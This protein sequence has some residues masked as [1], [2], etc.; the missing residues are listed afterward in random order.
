[1]ILSVEEMKSLEEKA[2]ADGV[3]ADVLMEEAGAQIARAVRQ[4]FPTPGVCVAV[5][6]KGNNGGDALVS[7]RHLAESGWEVLLIPAFSDDEWSPTVRRK[8][9]DAAGCHRRTALALEHTTGQP[10]VVLDGL[11]GIGA[12]GPLRDPIHTLTR[13]I[14]HLRQTAGA[15][16][17]ALDLPT[18]LNGDTGKAGT[19]CIIADTTLTIGFAKEGLLVDSATP[20]VGRLCVLPLRALSVRA[21]RECGETTVAT[22]SGLAHLLPRR[23]FD[24][25][26]GETGRIAVVAGSAPYMGAA[27]LCASGALRAGAG[28]VTL[29]VPN[30]ILQSIATRLPPEIILQ[31]TFALPEN[32]LKKHDVIAIGP[33]LGV[34]QRGDISRFVADCPLPMVVDAD[35]INAIAGSPDGLLRAPGARI[36]TPHPG[37]MARIDPE[38][39]NRSRLETV[40]AF[41]NRFPCTLLLKGARTIVG[42]AGMP[43][44][45]N[46]TGTPGMAKGGN[47][48]VLTGVIAALLGQRVKAYDAARLGAWLCG[49]A[50]ELAISHGGETEETLSPSRALDFL[51]A[52][53]RDLRG[54]RF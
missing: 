53:F 21:G 15:H 4:F 2:F 35:A 25:H 19:D 3:P 20:F 46:T 27:I 37:E 11:L 48:D 7:A 34:E 54:R 28:M 6:G 43:A 42:E 39:A 32:L 9:A 52:A 1:M 44:S 33:G 14:N 26:K 45:F 22:A 18:G 41:T 29:Y 10:L 24:T 12:D 5:F 38:S 51:S 16:V 40:K 8:F 49:R 50:S 13:S 30:E 17:F 23:G 31:P 47:G 36:L